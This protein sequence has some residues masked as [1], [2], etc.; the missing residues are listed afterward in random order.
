MN[1]EPSA[2]LS[3]SDQ[4]WLAAVCRHI[5]IAL[6]RIAVDDCCPNMMGTAGAAADTIEHIVSV[7]EYNAIRLPA[8][9]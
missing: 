2:H 3:R 1:F 4:D 9:H 6:G 5:C 8:V 7:T